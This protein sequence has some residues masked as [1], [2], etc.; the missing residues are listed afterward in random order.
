[1]LPAN[2]AKGRA[3]AAARGL[4]EFL[5]VTSGVNGGHA[6]SIVGGPG[7]NGPMPAMRYSPYTLPT[8][9]MEL[10]PGSG[11]GSS[12]TPTPTPVT[13]QQHNTLATLSTANGN[14]QANNFHQ[15]LLQA[16]LQQLQM[17]GLDFGSS[18]NAPVGSAANMNQLFGSAVS[19]KPR[20]LAFPTVTTQN[21][22]GYNMADLM[23][24][25]GYPGMDSSSYQV[26]VGLWTFRSL[27]LIVRSPIPC[28]LHHPSFM[29][30]CLSK[31]IDINHE[32]GYI[33]W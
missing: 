24:I 23:N 25:S 32:L 33:S 11:S 31:N 22:F 1:M 14:L 12:T 27:W 28:F 4:G 10:S 19:C 9:T 30:Y 13:I 15:A 21:S 3:A 29:Y 2:L 5:M 6:S 7:P 17:I 26:P 16:N 8:T 18:G 20:S